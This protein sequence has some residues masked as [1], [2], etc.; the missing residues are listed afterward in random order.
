[1]ESYI[2]AERPGGY[3]TVA[4][5]TDYDIPDH[6]ATVHP[7]KRKVTF[8][9]YNPAT[10][11]TIEKYLNLVKQFIANHKQPCAVYFY[12]DEQVRFHTYS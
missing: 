11:K 10:G 3:F 5:F 4:K 7:G 2:I 6:V 1:M 12:K 9:Y 8:D